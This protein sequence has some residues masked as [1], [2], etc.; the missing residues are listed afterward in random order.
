MLPPELMVDGSHARLT[1]QPNP[2]A[3]VVTGHPQSRA[4]PPGIFCGYRR[5]FTSSTTSGMP[6]TGDVTTTTA[7]RHGF[8]QCPRVGSSSWSGPT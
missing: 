4:P 2:D 3:G 8:E 1:D 5:P 6:P 7:V